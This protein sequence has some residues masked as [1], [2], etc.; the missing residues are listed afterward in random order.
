VAV[1]ATGLAVV[2]ALAYSGWRDVPHAWDVMRSQRSVYIGWTQA[3]RARAFGTQIPIPMEIFDYWRDALRPGDRYWLQ[4]PP[5]PFASYADK[6]YIARNIAHIYLLP[7]IE[8]SGPAD[9]TVVLSWD[10]SPAS[11]HLRY[12][13]VRQSGVQ[14]IY[15]SR[16]AHVG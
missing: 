12:A 16:V 10:A 3:Q 4:M 8:A 7:A 1:R 15:F 6:R 14:Q 2:A 11:L 13:E 5:E 9:A